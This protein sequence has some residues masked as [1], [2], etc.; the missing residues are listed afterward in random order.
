M[1]V[2]LVVN[3][4]HYLPH[5]LAVY[6]Q[7]E[8]DERAGINPFLGLETMPRD[9]ALCAGWADAKAARKLR[10]RRVVLMEHG[11]GQSYLGNS[12]GRRGNPHYVGGAE[13]AQVLDLALLPN[14]MA[15]EVERRFN[16]T[17]PVAVVG[18][19]WLDVLESRAGEIPLAAKVTVAFHWNATGVAP[20]A[21]SAFREYR[22]AVDRLEGAVVHAHPRADEQAAWYRGRHLWWESDPLEAVMASPVLVSDN[23]S[24]LYY[25]AALGR[26]VVVVNAKGWRKDVHHG[27]RFW[28]HAGVGEQVDTPFSLRDVVERAPQWYRDNRRER[29][30]LLAEVFPW[31]GN[32]RQMAVAALRTTMQPGPLSLD[33]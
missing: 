25:G 11:C 3:Q 13:R 27:L 6:Q 1:P 33:T 8:P 28:S 12:D 16:P 22:Y 10:Y 21:G 18:S 24:I 32:A 7:L 9:V 23:S 20:E 14:T 31:R 19:P 4:R 26:S 30:R 5:L 17:L 2:A 29:A 15:A